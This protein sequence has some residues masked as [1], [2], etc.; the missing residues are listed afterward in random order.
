[1]TIRT[2]IVGI[3]SFLFLAL[4]LAPAHADKEAGGIS[5]G[6]DEP[7]SGEADENENSYTSDKKGDNCFKLGTQFLGYRYRSG[8][9]NG[10]DSSQHELLLGNGLFLFGGYQIAKYYEIGMNL[11]LQHIDT[12]SGNISFSTTSFWM[13]PYF[14]I[15]PR[16][17]KYIV[18][19]LQFTMGLGLLDAPG[20]DSDK[21]FIVG[22]GLGLSGKPVDYFSLDLMLRFLYSVGGVDDADAYRSLYVIPSFGFTVWI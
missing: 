18:F 4:P 19:P 13:L 15:N 1:M 6:G 3:V 12:S 7:V 10:V 11:S 22:G 2:V 20:I 21:Y 8:N 17:G 9:I 5:I 14:Q 16:A